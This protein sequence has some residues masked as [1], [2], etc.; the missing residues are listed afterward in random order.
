MTISMRE[1][2]STLMV[3]VV[4]VSVG[5]AGS[6]M[7]SNGQMRNLRQTRSQRQMIKAPRLI[8][9]EEID[10][11]D[12]PGILRTRTP[13][14]WLVCAEEDGYMLLIPDEDG[15]W[16]IDAQ[17]SGLGRE[18]C[19]HQSHTNGPEVS[20]EKTTRTLIPGD[21]EYAR[22]INSHISEVFRIH[23]SPETTSRPIGGA[24]AITYGFGSDLFLIYLIKDDRVISAEWKRYLK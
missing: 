9:W 10:G 13:N 6:L 20:K 3:A 11:A 15:D 2:I 19:E 18:L 14:G 21:I 16:L 5:A 17:E 12:G 24:Y 4:G 22:P 7:H 1:M 8:Q 23:G